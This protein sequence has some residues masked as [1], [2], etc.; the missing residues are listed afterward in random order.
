MTPR[1]FPHPAASGLRQHAS[2]GQVSSSP[3][4]VGTILND[5]DEMPSDGH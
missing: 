3:T 4:F 1:R 2:S 5:L